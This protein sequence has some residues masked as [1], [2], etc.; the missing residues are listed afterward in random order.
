MEYSIVSLLNTGDSLGESPVWIAGER[1]LYWVDVRKPCIHSFDPTTRDYRCI[2]LP[3]IVGSIVERAQGGLAVV[4]RNGFAFWDGDEPAFQALDH[5]LGDE[6]FNDAKCD[7]RGRL[8]TG[9][10]DRE[11][12]GGMAALYRIDPSLHCERIDGPFSI[13]N[14]LAWSPDYTRF[15]FTDTRSRTIFA[16]D[17]DLESGRAS[18]RRV[19]A[20]IAEEEGGRPDGC[21]MD[22]EGCLWSVMVGGGRIAR[23]AP[24]GRKIDDIPVPVLH[25]T[26]CCFGGPDLKTLFVTS[27]QATVSTAEAAH[28]PLDGATFAIALPVAG[29]PVAPFGG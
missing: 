6:R 18:N 16:Y 4:F 5:E 12:R 13:G 15:Y 23:Y 1:R 7:A 2:V 14:G 10:L 22:V 8:W 11:L 29:M 3:R 27:A 17:Y 25:P 24:D 19:F 9:T 20:H 21:A 26:S 28:H